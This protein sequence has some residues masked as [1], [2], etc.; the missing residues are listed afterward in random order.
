MHVET[1]NYI[2]YD[3]GTTIH[4]R[5]DRPVGHKRKDGYLEFSNA[6]DNR[7]KTLA[8]RF[9][10][11]VFNGEIPN[12]MQVNHVNGVK[13]DNRLVNL[14]LVTRQHNQQHCE[15][16]N[17]NT[18]GH[19][20]ICWRKDCEKWAVRIKVNGKNKHFGTFDNIED[21][22]NKRDEAIRELNA[23]GHRYIINF[24]EV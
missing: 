15:K 18:S 9:I 17:N 14:E 16:R 13:D 2:V 22:I 7:K 21:A 1:P 3:D 20:N 12:G 8:H 19:K 10:W 5:F 6:D 11:K 23:T 24:P 4:K